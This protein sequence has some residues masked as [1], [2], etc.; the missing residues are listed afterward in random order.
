MSYPYGIVFIVF[1]VVVI[2][3]STRHRDGVVEK[4]GEEERERRVPSGIAHKVEPTADIRSQRSIFCRY[5][6]SRPMVDAACR[7]ISRA[8]LCHAVRYHLA[9]CENHHESPKDRRRSCKEWQLSNTFTTHK[10]KEKS[11]TSCLKTK[12]VLRG[13]GYQHCNFC[14]TKSE[15]AKLVQASMQ[16]CLVSKPLELQIIFTLF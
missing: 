3:L 1:T 6:L 7:W 11:F 14:K 13:K 8:D 9:H 4:F 5:Q 15:V 2:R 12:T 16:H 10:L